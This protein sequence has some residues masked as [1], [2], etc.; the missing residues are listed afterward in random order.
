MT[1]LRVG[2]QVTVDEN[3]G[4]ETGADSDDQNDPVAAFA[5]A[6]SHFG[7]AGDVGVIGHLNGTPGLLGKIRR[8]REPDKRSVDIGGCT[9][10]PFLDVQ[11]SAHFSYKHR[12]IEVDGFYDGVPVAVSTMAALIPVPPTSMPRIC[13]IDSTRNYSGA[14]ASLS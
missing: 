2:Q 6:E 11:F 9:G 1:E 12:T 8:H 5:G 4:A 14:N 7:E 3:G 10:N 13:T